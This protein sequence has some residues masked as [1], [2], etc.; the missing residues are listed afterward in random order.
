MGKRE[1][2]EEGEALRRID[3]RKCCSMGR[4]TAADAFVKAKEEE[5]SRR[6]RLALRRTKLQ[7]WVHA[8]E[9][10]CRGRSHVRA[11]RKSWK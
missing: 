11:R 8:G 9:Q 10:A 4:S 5:E 7:V 2:E 6:M 3:R 1:K